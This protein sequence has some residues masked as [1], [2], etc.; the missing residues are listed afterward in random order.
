VSVNAKEKTLSS[1][2][3]QLI[4]AQVDL[5]DARKQLQKKDTELRTQQYDF[6]RTNAANRRLDVSCQELFKLVSRLRNANEKAARK[7]HLLE[8]EKCRAEARSAQFEESIAHLHN[9][10]AYVREQLTKNSKQMLELETVSQCELGRLKAQIRANSNLERRPTASADFAPRDSESHTMRIEEL[11]K[12]NDNLTNEV[13]EL[14][15][16]VERLATAGDR[17]PLAE[18]RSANQSG[19]SGEVFSLELREQINA[20]QRQLE[21]IQ[22]DGADRSRDLAETRRVMA[23]LLE[24]L[25][26]A[27]CESSAAE[28][29][30]ANE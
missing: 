27:Q 3:E 20:V 16:E 11:E 4:R 5:H 28:D 10:N 22:S 13:G 21:D 9:D 15:R 7:L 23:D 18:T 8:Q 17:Q 12:L 2:R 25:A 1:L 6:E 14:R 24:N 19:P 30:N 29:R 26:A